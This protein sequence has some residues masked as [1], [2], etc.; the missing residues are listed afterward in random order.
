MPAPAA[1]SVLFVC[2]GNICRSPTAEA[3][4]RARAPDLRLDSAGTGDWHIGAPPHPPA[5]AA[6][7]ARGY[8]MAGM[9]A[10]QI[11]PEDFSR[12][13]RIVVMDTAN[14]RAVEALRPAGASVPVT[15]LLDHVAG[16]GQ[17]DVPDP[18]LTG[19]FTEALALIEAGVDGLLAALGR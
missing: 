10:R 4:A 9:R 2:L 1:S 17:T 16:C 15:R 14:L 13:D 3:M 5:V 7:T 12:F 18:Y 8:T 19:D 11:T 6:A